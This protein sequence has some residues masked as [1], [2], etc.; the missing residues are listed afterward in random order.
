MWTQEG[1]VSEL[2]PGT[3]A[4]LEP[5]VGSHLAFTCPLSSPDKEARPQAPSLSSLL[6]PSCGHLVLCPALP[7]LTE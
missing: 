6:T 4:S 7:G 2:G 5:G 1:Q 3:G